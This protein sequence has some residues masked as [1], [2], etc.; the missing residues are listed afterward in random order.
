MCGGNN[1]YAIIPRL[2]CYFMCLHLNIHACCHAWENSQGELSLENVLCFCFG[3]HSWWGS[4]FQGLAILMEC[5]SYT[6]CLRPHKLLERNSCRVLWGRSQCLQHC[7]GSVVALQL[8]PS[9]VKMMITCSAL[10][11]EF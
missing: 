1:F 5:R 8:Q 10:P 7:C 9:A 11:L 3:K 2:F 6:A 4:G